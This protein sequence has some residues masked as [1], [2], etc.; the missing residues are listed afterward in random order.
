MKSTH[1]LFSFLI[2][3]LLSSC[4]Q[5]N[6]DAQAKNAK[7]KA[8]VKSESPVDLNAKSAPMNGY[9]YYNLPGAPTMEKKQQTS[10]NVKPAK[11]AAVKK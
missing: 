5:F 9:N 8:K 1:L 7:I 2:L 3:S 4:S 11:K 10:K 6:T